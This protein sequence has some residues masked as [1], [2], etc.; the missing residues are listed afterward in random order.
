MT[1]RFEFRA[2]DAQ[3]DHI[4]DFDRYGGAGNFWDMCLAHDWEIMQCTGLK[5]KN[6]KLIYEGDVVRFRVKDKEWNP[7][8]NVVVNF[9]DGQ[10]WAGGY[11]F[12]EI[13]CE[14]IGNIHENPE[15]LAKDDFEG[16]S[17][18]EVMEE[19]VKEI[20]ECRKDNNNKGN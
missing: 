16:L 14:I 1:D 12:F 8:K 4:V 18:D 13:K 2:W 20:K 17:E 10:F 6:R 11:D 3:N 7:Y 19:V 9:E 5:D 15:L